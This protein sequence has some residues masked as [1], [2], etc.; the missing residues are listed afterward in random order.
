MIL[1]KY[2]SASITKDINYLKIPCTQ[3]ESLDEYNEVVRY[4]NDLYDKGEINRGFEWTK[5]GGI[6]LKHIYHQLNNYEVK[7]NTPGTFHEIII[8]T[9]IDYKEYVMRLQY[10]T[11]TTKN[12]KIPIPGK[13]AYMSFK[14][15]LLKDGIDIEM[16]KISREEGEQ[17]KA[18]IPSPLIKVANRAFLNKTFEHCYHL[19][20]NSAYAAG[21]A[22]LYP[23]WKPTIERIYDN[24]KGSPLKKAILNETYGFMQS[25]MVGYKFTHISKYCVES[26][27]NKLNKLTDILN[28]NDSTVIIAYNTDGIWFQCLDIDF[29]TWIE[30]NICRETLGQAKIDFRDCKLRYKSPGAYEFIERGKYHVVLRG[31]CNKDKVK[32]RDEWEWGDI[33]NIIEYMFKESLEEY[34]II[35]KEEICQN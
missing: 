12:Q 13:R 9:I 17:V 7:R 6:S 23:E 14:Y 34:G 19:D 33:Y 18:N 29:I 35:L 16:Y 11:G 1:D 2:K 22:E 24:R 8:I 25:R 10:W 27:I 4:L 31:F 28:S 32:P 21:M 20:L 30:K 3:I 5:S 26:C 15:E